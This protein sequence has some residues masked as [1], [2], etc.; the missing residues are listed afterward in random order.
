MASV[1]QKEGKSGISWEA[2]IHRKG[3]PA[4]S[5]SF[6]TKKDA[7]TWAREQEGKIDKGKSI[8]TAEGFSVANALE[9]Y[10][11]HL[12]SKKKL[13]ASTKA[14]F[15]TLNV[16]LGQFGISV[17]SAAKL[18]AFILGMRELEIPAPSTA[19]KVHP[20]YNGGKPKKYAEATIR[21]LVYALKTT[22][23]WHAKTHGYELPLHLF[24]FEKPSSWSQ[25]RER[26]LEDGEE[27]K[28]LEACRFVT[29]KNKKGESVGKKPRAH[30]DAYASLFIFALETAGRLGEILQ[31]EWKEVD[32]EK[33]LWNIPG[34]KS[35]TRR[36]RIVELSKKAVSA[37]T[38][39]QPDRAQRNG[40]IFEELP[41][42]KAKFVTW[43]RILQDAGSEKLGWHDCRH[44]AISRWVIRGG[45]DMKISAM[46]GH[47]IS[48]MQRY[49]HLRPK[50]LSSFIDG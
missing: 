25:P 4:L 44:E 9:E 1:R 17:L 11:T 29:T 13:D 16:H 37:L 41:A 6:S 8:R 32:L 40:V 14:R 30:G 2:R 49:V 19:R 33:R 43:K 31:A 36:G 47:A 3:Y 5:R 45:S 10:A 15:N 46:A 38:T 26:R 22:L 50:E 21:K 18:E 20:L 28:V 7:L 24:D 34:P 48:V 23:D 35:K 27:E 42:G 39:L 12:D